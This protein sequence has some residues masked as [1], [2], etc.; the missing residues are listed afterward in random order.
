ML[1]GHQYADKFLS[2]TQFQWQ[3]Q[4]ATAQASKRGQQIIEHRKQGLAVHL[5][6]RKNKKM[7]NKATPFVYCGEVSLYSYENEKP[8]NV[9]WQL[10]DSLPQRLADE[11]V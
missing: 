6:V 10:A 7:A 9:V 4:N 2:S 1:D 3:S 5:F 8:I 11:F